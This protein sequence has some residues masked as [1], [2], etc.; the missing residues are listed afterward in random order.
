ME[1]PGSVGDDGESR[2]GSVDD[3][4]L[5]VMVMGGILEGPAIASCGSAPWRIGELAEW[6]A[7]DEDDDECD[8]EDA[9]GLTAEVA[10]FPV[11]DAFRRNS[12]LNFI[13][14]TSCKILLLI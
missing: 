5:D 1:G 7:R 4:I 3:L 6:V 10:S 14:W 13:I 2:F 12:D 9:D 11:G 8:I